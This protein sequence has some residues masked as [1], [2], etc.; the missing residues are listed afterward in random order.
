MEHT[1]RATRRRVAVVT[2]ASAGVGRATAVRL[3]Q[4]GY[5]VGMISRG[6]HGLLAAADDVLAHGG[7]A[8][9]VQA[10]VGE[11]QEVQLAAQEIESRLGQIDV[12]INN[13]MTTVFSPVSELA[14]AEVRR[15]TETTYL[16][17][18]HGALAALELMRPRNNG[19]IVSVSSALAYRSIPLQ[20]AYCAGKAA[21]RAF[22]DGLRTELLHEH[23][24]IRISQ[25]VLPAVNTPQFQW[26]CSKMHYAPRPVAPV[27]SAELAAR[28]IVGAAN[29]PS[30]QR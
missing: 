23:S 22:F 2:G 3:A 20:V 10:D 14:A 26:S 9:A 27:Y 24:S 30:R 25:V 7:R 16:G 28:A 8:V 29:H 1:D 17:Q 13:A 4:R 5:D 12:W 6:E 19:T 15:V 21:A 11:W 18:V